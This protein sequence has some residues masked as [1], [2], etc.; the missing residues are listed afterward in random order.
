MRRKAKRKEPKE[1]R[2][3]QKRDTSVKM[4]NIS[5]TI[6]MLADRKRMEPW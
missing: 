5:K 3:S 4:V 1:I 2:I 6:R